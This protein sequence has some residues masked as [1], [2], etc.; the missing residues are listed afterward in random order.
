MA[1]PPG[2]LPSSCR[3]CRRHHCCR[4]ASL[5]TVLCSLSLPSAQVVLARH[6]VTGEL[7]ALKVR[8]CLR[9][10]CMKQQE[11]QLRKLWAGPI[12]M[13]RCA[14][15]NP[16][17]AAECAGGCHCSACRRVAAGALHGPIAAILL[18]SYAHGVSPQL[19]Q[20]VFL[21]SPAVVDDHEHLAILQRC[22]LCVGVRASSRGALLLAEGA[23]R[24]GF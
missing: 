19:L 6:R 4:S 8:A 23:Q 5:T 18:S 13:L 7:A 22:A 2:A 3:R 1:L 24:G 11:T 10:E 14:P 20:V 9:R 21:E 16:L 12:H 15:C 17:R